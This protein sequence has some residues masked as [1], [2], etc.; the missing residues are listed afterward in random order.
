MTR[1]EVQLC[2]TT[3]TTC[4]ENRGQGR[5]GAL[6][7]LR[8]AA[9]FKVVYGWGLRRTET[10]K[11]DL[12]DLRRNRQAPQFGRYGTLNVRYGKSSKGQPP[13][14]GTC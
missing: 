11:L 9:V 3:P 12:V 7:A 14:G 1:E 13:R 10:S 2:S 5:K 6:A 4:V 8:D